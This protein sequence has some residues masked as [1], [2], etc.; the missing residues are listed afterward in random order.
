MAA[1]EERIKILTMIQAGK[2]SPE[3]GIRLLQILDESRG[4]SARRG[5]SGG[6][7]ARGAETA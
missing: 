3:E 4:Q 2:L 6:P 5:A 7:L 1:S